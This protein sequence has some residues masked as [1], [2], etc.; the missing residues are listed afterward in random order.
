[1]DIKISNSLIQAVSAD[2]IL[3][4]LY[5]GVDIS[6][7]ATG[8][9]DM[10]LNGAVSELVNAKDVLSVVEWTRHGS[11]LTP[12]CV[13]RLPLQGMRSRRCAFAG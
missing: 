7:G 6:S 9:V 3:V 11:L 4:N 2:A 10:A 12:W 5:E 13:F 1:M 8:A